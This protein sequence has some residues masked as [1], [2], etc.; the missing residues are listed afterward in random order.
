MVL[1][2]PILPLLEWL[3]LNLPTFAIGLIGVV[4]L[5]LLIGFL[6]GALRHG[7]MGSLR[8]V[9]QTISAALVDFRHSSPRRIFA[10][11]RLAFQESLRRRVLV[12]FGVFVLALLFAGWFLDPSSKHP[13][14]LYLSFVLTSTNYL[15]LLLAVFLSAFSLPNDIKNRTIYTIVTKPV[16]PWEIVVG[17][18]LGFSAVGT[19]LLILMCVFSYFFVKRGLQH[20]H[21]IAPQEMVNQTLDIDGDSM[22][23]QTGESS[24]TMAHRHEVTVGPDGRVSV[25]NEHD[26]THAI[27]ETPE[28][29]R[30]G[31]YLLGKPEGFLEARVPVRGSL[32]FIDSSGAPGSGTNVGYENKYRKYIEGGSLAAA[33][34]T[35]EDVRPEDFPEGLPIEMTLRV[36]RTFQGDIEQGL[37]GTIQLVK[38]ALRDENG[39]LIGPDTSWRSEEISFPAQDYTTFRRFIPRKIEARDPQG[40]EKIVDIFEELT[41]PETGSIEIWI[42]CLDSGQYLGMAPADL[43]LR[44]SDR[45]FWLNFI[46]GYTSIWFQLVVVTCFGVMFSTILS[47]PVAMMSTLAA[48]VMGFFKNFVFDVASGEMPG[49]GPLES[50]VRLIQQVGQ[51]TDLAPGLGTTIITRIDDVLMLVIQTVSYAMPDCSIF[52]TSRFVAYGFNIPGE[53]MVQHF[54][55]TL[56]YAIVASIVGYF[57]LRT[58]EIAA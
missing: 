17:R 48:V 57:C 25:S 49:G 30:D 5:G 55:I 6:A 31:E 7:P 50:L 29:S 18:M 40:N 47:G 19:T 23:Q 8:I 9:L 33:I 56:A 13:A 2:K 24:L 38:P 14:R 28:S 39:I 15:V 22:E 44:A 41:D 35:F 42:R 58:R 11:A 52:N 3:R 12:V 20:S 1:E 46:K 27:A 53:L 32:R 51:M 21:Q 37:T 4:V 34:W 16:R 10:I 45:P 26:H 43:Y 54:L 36:F